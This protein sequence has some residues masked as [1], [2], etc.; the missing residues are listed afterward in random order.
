[1]KIYEL[2]RKYLILR[3]ISYL[4][5]AQCVIEMSAM[6][7]SWLMTGAI[8]AGAGGMELVGG[9]LTRCPDQVP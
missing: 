4:K 9:A 1:M 5:I 8:V 3:L 7:D 2:R 6:S